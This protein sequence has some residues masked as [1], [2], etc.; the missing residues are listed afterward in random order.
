MMF[1]R[2]QK[3]VIYSDFAPMP[4]TFLAN[5]TNN[6]LVFRQNTR[7]YFDPSISNLFNLIGRAMTVKKERT[8]T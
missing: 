5:L 4:D 8:R 7:Y 1:D 3:S 2:V 6:Y